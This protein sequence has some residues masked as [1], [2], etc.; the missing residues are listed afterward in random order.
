M[1]YLKKNV[2]GFFR[3]PV[4]YLHKVVACFC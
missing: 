2:V 4:L 1:K 3:L